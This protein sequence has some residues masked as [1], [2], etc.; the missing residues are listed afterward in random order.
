[1]HDGRLLRVPSDAARMEFAT[2]NATAEFSIGLQG[3]KL[4]GSVGQV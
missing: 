1:M 2:T 4:G 3:V